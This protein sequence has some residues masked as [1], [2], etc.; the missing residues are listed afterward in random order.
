MNISYLDDE[1]ALTSLLILAFGLLIC[2]EIRSVNSQASINAQQ[3]FDVG[4]NAGI[5]IA[6]CFG[7][8]FLVTATINLLRWKFVT[9]KAAPSAA[10]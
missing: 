7:L 3:G 2:C 4:K 9:T 10:I 5:A 1:M 8:L 6:I